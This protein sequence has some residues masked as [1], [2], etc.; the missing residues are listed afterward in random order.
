MRSTFRRILRRVKDNPPYP[1][2]A[3]Y[4]TVSTPFM[5]TWKWAGKLQ[6]KG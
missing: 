3:D 6:K 5:P 1:N 2:L 4:L